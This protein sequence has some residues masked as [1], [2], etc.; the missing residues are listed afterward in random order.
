MADDGSSP[1]V[2]VLPALALAAVGLYYVYGAL[3]RVGLEAQ[4]AAARI[5]S[6]LV[7]P[8]STTY[9]TTTVAGRAWTQSSANPEVHV[10][11][12]EIGGEPAGAAVSPEFY[13]SVQTGDVM[14]VEFTRTRFSNRLVVTD[15]RHETD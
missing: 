13:A 12:F 10:L 5:A 9:H 14:R 3:D 6:T 8:G 1:F 15:V 2:Y 11:T 7:A 4:H